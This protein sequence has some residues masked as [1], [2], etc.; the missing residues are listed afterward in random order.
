MRH[1]ITAHD[2]LEIILRSYGENQM[3]RCDQYLLIVPVVMMHCSSEHH[4]RLPAHRN[5]LQTVSAPTGGAMI[6]HRSHNNV[7][8]ALK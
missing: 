6:D 5:T 4:A 3:N 1:V 2:S 8:S 7:D